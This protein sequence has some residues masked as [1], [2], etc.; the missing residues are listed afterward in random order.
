MKILEY[1]LMED[2]KNVIN[3]K[4]SEK[5]FNEDLYP[6]LIAYFNIG[7]ISDF[8]AYFSKIILRID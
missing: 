4:H 3:E 2:K 8:I 6:I 7:F 5:A 1:I